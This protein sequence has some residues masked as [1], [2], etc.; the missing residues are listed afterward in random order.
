M[1]FNEFGLTGK[2]NKE[3]GKALINKAQEENKKT[4]EGQVVGHVGTIMMQL[5]KMHE[6][7]ENVESN[8]SLLQRKIQAVNDG[9]FTLSPYGVITFN[10]KELQEAVIGLIECKNCGYSANR[11]STGYDYNKR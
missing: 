3:I 8:I 5:R 1:K 2:G 7:K 9:E 10:D 4:L 6:Y 11:S